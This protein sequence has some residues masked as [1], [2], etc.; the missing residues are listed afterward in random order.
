MRAAL[1]RASLGYCRR[2]KCLL[3]DCTHHRRPIVALSGY[4]SAV[5]RGEAGCD[6]LGVFTRRTDVLL[7]LRD[8]ECCAV[9]RDVA[10]L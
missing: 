7:L 8:S 1:L 10:Q 9:V 2:E 5:W 4:L 6:P 3:C